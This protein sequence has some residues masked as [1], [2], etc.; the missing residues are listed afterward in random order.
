MPSLPNPVVFI[1]LKLGGY[2]VAGVLLN[3][4]FKKEAFPPLFGIARF[5]AG[6]GLGVITIPVA[7]YSSYLWIVGLRIVAWFAL[8]YFFYRPQNDLNRTFYLAV[9][10]GVAYSF[11]LDGIL[12]LISLIFPGS[13]MKIPWF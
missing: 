4:L 9:L 13:Q 5:L 8:I 7:T 1:A 12:S 6:L 11:V 2:T 3:K 10:G